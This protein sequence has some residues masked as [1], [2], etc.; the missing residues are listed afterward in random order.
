M[1]SIALVQAFSRAVEPLRVQ[2]PLTGAE[3]ANQHFYLSPESSGTAGRWQCYP[4]Q[5]AWLDWMTSDDIEE[6]NF[7]KSRRVGYTKCLMAATG[8]LIE[9]KNR[10]V[11]IWHPTDG[12]AK[13]FVVDEID[14]LLRDVPVLGRKLKCPVGAKNKY[15]TL[16]K[17]SFHGATLDIKGGKSARNF[18]RMTKDVAIYDET[19]GFDMDIDGEGSCFELGDGRLD[20]APFPKSIRGSTPKTKGLSLI[21]TAV[22]NSDRIFYRF[23][24]C[25]E[26]GALQRLEFKGLFWDANTPES[27]RYA[28]VSGCDLQYRQLPQMDE[29]GRWQTMDGVWYDEHARRFFDAAGRQISAPRKIGVRIWA[30]YSYLRPWSYIVDRWL[31]AVKNAK[32]GNVTTLKTVINTLLGETFEEEGSGVAASSLEGR[33]ED[34][35]S[36]GC[37]PNE[38]LL[39]TAG[40]DVQGGANARI[41]LEILGHGLDDETW[42]LGY[43]V[44]SGDPER[45]EVWDNLD[46]HLLKRYRRQDGVQLAVSAAFI[47]SGYLATEVYRFA[48]PRR[49]RAVYATKGVNTGTI[50]NKGTWQGEKQNRTRTILR[51]VNVDDAKTIIFN[52]LQIEKPGPGYCHFPAHYTA[53]YYTQLTNE[54]RVAKHRKGVLVGYEWR[55]K[56]RNEPLDCRAY[57]LGAKE[58]LNPNMQRLKVRLE[59]RA[60]SSVEAQPTDTP[61]KTTGSR[62]KRTRKRGFVEGW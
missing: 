41:E 44:I 13:D 62:R 25:P 8:C 50:C 3:W 28:C 11:A 4:Y 21:E 22:E 39:I 19:D 45:S 24:K 9:Q 60:P 53:D 37:I 6:V 2:V 23:V 59:Q 33:G 10:N 30:G 5:V 1:S 31:D 20:Q 52:R 34:Y 14:T 51:T 32:A 47:D 58:F 18:R 38:V 61:E 54:E 42:S 35:L 7:Q 48:A 15:N 17:K 55:K 43:F 36:D 26:C 46:S 16:E 12:D 40:A 27:V 49:K 29:A 56:G 57:A